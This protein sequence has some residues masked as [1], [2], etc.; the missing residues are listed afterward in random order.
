MRNLVSK[1]ENFLGIIQGV[2]YGSASIKKEL[3][4]FKKFIPKAKIFID[5]GGN[6]GTYSEGIIQIYQPDEIHI[7]EPAK[8]NIDI[9]KSKF[10]HNTK[11]FIN[12]CGLSN[13][14]SNSILYSNKSGSGLGSLTKRRLDHF[15]IDFSIEENIN[16]MRFDEYW[17]KNI[18]KKIIDLFK[19]DVEGHELEVLEGIGNNIKNIKVIQ[20]EFGGCNIDTRTYFQDYWY[21]FKNNNF[22]IYRITPFGKQEIKK[23]RETNERFITTNY[24]CV[25]KKFLE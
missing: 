19:I 21:F 2:G 12:D 7:F 6:I 20:F 8:K 15:G 1:F 16:L 25:N 17:E 9:L 24:F 3:N 10:N 4:S 18:D 5:V 22:D 23:Y 13:I 11:I 14:N